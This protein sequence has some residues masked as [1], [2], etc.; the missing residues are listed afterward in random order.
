MWQVKTSKMSIGTGV[1]SERGENR[2]KSN[3]NEIKPLTKSNEIGGNNNVSQV[4]SKSV[5]RY[6]PRL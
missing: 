4:Q 1:D 3:F 2:F 6:R 5:C